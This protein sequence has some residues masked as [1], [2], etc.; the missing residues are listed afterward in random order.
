[1]RQIQG[2]HKFVEKEEKEGEETNIYWVPS[3]HQT[4][5]LAHFYFFNLIFS[6]KKTT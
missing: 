1:M 2:A 5:N 3:S 4:L 6:Y